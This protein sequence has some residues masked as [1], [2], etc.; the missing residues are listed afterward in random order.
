MKLGLTIL[1]V[2]FLHTI[3]LGQ[4][5]YSHNYTV[6]DGLPSNAV[7][8]IYK[9]TKD[10]MWVGTAAGLCLFD[11][12]G[13]KVLGSENGLV[14]ESIFSITEDEQQ[15]IWIGSMKGG[16]SKY[17]GK[18]FTNYTTNEGLVSDNVRV[19]WYSKKFHLLFIGTDD[20][21]SVFDGKS[22]ISLRAR[23]TKTPDLFMMGFLEGKDFVCCYPYD[24]DKYYNY[25]PKTKTF[26]PVLDPYYSRHYPSTSPLIQPNGD[27]IMGNFREGINVFHN[28]IKVST[29]PTPYFLAEPASLPLAQKAGHDK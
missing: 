2:F 12:K 25:Y 13:F 4:H 26:K 15:N 5:Y 18:T 24:H 3:V 11:G 27:T 29:P 17:D 8:C 10:R 21:C 14:G 7:R 28:G 22:F 6:N 9:D 1:I 16:I 20:G 23:D 19:V